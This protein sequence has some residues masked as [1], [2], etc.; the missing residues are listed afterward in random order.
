MPEVKNARVGFISVV[1][2]DVNIWILLICASGAAL[3][4]LEAI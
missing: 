1:I 3:Q 4:L 2:E